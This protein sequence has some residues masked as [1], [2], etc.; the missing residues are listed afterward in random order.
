MRHSVLLIS[1]DPAHN[2]SDTFDQKISKF[3]TQIR[4]FQNLFAMVGNKRSG[5]LLHHHFLYFRKLIPRY[6]TRMRL[7]VNS[8]GLR[9]VYRAL[10]KSYCKMS[11]A[12]YPV[13]MRPRAS[14]KSWG[15][16]VCYQFNDV[17]VYLVLSLSYLLL[18]PI[19]LINLRP[20]SQYDTGAMSIMSI[21]EKS[22]CSW[23]KCY[24][25]CPKF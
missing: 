4:G 23:S 11:Q 6:L 21:A 3:P 8:L 25:Y 19:S 7:K 12:H 13:S 5:F 14:F 2:L 10:Q 16:C 15:M 17:F 18:N 24:S 9:G 1:T 20:G 22:A